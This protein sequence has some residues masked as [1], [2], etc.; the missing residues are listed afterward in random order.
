M[1]RILEKSGEVS[2]YLPLKHSEVV[3]PVQLRISIS[4]K[5]RMC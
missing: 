3:I 1:K 4:W 5:D 2:E